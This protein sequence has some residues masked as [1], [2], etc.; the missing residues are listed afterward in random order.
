M[1]A[2][3]SCGSNSALS[4]RAAAALWGIR[5]L[6]GGPI[7]VS[8]PLAVGRSPRGV[9]MH[10][11]AALG[12][13]EV[14]RRY[15]I[16]VTNA[17]GTLLDL[18]SILDRAQLEA[19]VNEADKQGFVDPERLR[20][21]LD[22][23]PRRPGIRPLRELL[24]RLTFTLTDSELE[25]LFLPLASG[26]SLPRPETG[27]YLNGFKV[28]FFWPGLGLVVETDG[29]R[30]H[31]TPSQQARMAKRDQTHVASGFRVLRFTHWQI[32]HAPDEVTAVLRQ[33]R[34]HLRR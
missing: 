22:K 23:L 2:V 14:T 21:A 7:E 5:E 13:A 20:S 19:A 24:D 31:R 29:L 12:P 4:H 28:D 8:V 10:R 9:I 16:P 25:R 3:L 11:R 15:G 34:P 17:I 32:A 27:R 18:A 26:A 6:Q 30:Y 33:I 1:A